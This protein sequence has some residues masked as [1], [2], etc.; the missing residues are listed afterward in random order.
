MAKRV[1]GK[2]RW[3]MTA[4][5]PEVLIL[6]GKKVEMTFCPPLPERHPRFV[7]VRRVP[8]K[9]SKANSICYSTA[10]WRGY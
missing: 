9:I 3:D 4:Q 1:N 8:S 5:I 6:R 10:C 7:K 2:A